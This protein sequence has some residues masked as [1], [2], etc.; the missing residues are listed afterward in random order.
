MGSEGPAAASLTVDNL[1]RQAAR[2]LGNVVVRVECSQAAEAPLDRV[3]SLMS[4]PAFWSLRRGRC[5]MFD[6][7]GADR[8][9]FC[10]SALSG[11]VHCGAFGI[12]AG[13]PGRRMSLQAHYG[14]RGRY[15]LSATARGRRSEA[16]IAVMASVPR[17][18]EATI[19]ASLRADLGSWLRLLRQVSEGRAAWPGDG[20]PAELHAMCMTR[21]PMDSGHTAATSV[22]IGAEPGSVWELLYSPRTAQLIGPRPAAFSGHVPGTPLR[23]PGEL[24]YF[25][26]PRPDGTLSAG[27]I[28]VTDY[29]GGLRTTAQRLGPPHDELR[30]ELTP[31]DGQAQLTLTWRWPGT[32]ELPPADRRQWAANLESLAR[33]YKL[34]SENG[35]PVAGEGR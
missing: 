32:A 18:R 9:R 29:D 20:I 7:P 31:G 14:Y 13:E 28:A 26:R 22:A 23:Q 10:I 16:R 24:Q 6:V 19:K 1:P 15:T 3:W 34:L 21:Q 17:G 11:E 30:Y 5:F 4:S 12:E 35:T 8:L 25:L 2:S 27:A 33:S